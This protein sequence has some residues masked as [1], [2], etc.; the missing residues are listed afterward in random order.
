MITPPSWRRRPAP[1]SCC[2]ALVSFVLGYIMYGMIFMALGSL[3]DTI[4]EA[5]TLLSPMMILLM[6]P[7]FA[8]FIAF[9]DPGSPGGGLCHLDPG[10]HALPA[11]PAHAA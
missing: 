1:R 11:D 7:M 8:I 5:Q 6:L 3:C 4:Q 2:P 9:Q 10:V